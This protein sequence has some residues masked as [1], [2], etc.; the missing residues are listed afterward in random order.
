MDGRSPQ[1]QPRP[2]PAQR[3]C[4]NT[5]LATHSAGRRTAGPGSTWGEGEASW[6]WQG[7]LPFFSL[8]RLRAER[9]LLTPL[10]DVCWLHGRPQSALSTAWGVLLGVTLHGIIFPFSEP[11]T[12]ALPLD[13]SSLSSLLSSPFTSAGIFPP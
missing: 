3:S 5:S 2:H 12:P 11:L 6:K 7:P 1:L 9:C 8:S 4:L 10:S 13:I